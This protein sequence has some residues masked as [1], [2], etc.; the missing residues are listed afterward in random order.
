MEENLFGATGVK[1]L[2]LASHSLAILFPP[3]E[4]CIPSKILCTSLSHLQRDSIVAGTEFNY[5]VI[6]DFQEDIEKRRTGT[7]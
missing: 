2:W 4:G 7:R 5:R 6:G 3:V 1:A